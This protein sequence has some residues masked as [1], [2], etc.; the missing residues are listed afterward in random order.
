MADPKVPSRPQ[1]YRMVGGDHDA[2]RL[3]QRLFEVA[4]DLTPA[5]VAAATGDITALAAVVSALTLDDLQG[6]DVS[7]AA[8]RDVLFYDGANWMPEPMDTR[9]KMRFLHG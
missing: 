6:V 4:G 1:I 7:A 5:S 3:L 8:N 2:A 9:A